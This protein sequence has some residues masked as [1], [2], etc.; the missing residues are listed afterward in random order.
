MYEKNRKSPLKSLPV[1]TVVF[2]FIGFPKSHSTWEPLVFAWHLICIQ[3][4]QIKLKLTCF[5]FSVLLTLFLTLYLC[6]DPGPRVR[7]RVWKRD[8]Q[9][10]GM[11]VVPILL[12]EQGVGWRIGDGDLQHHQTLV[13]QREHLHA[14]LIPKHTH[15]HTFMFTDTYS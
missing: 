3:S 11:G 13:G 10:S 8:E 1:L 5:H 12:G 14:V 4:N 6:R 2:R 7:Q 15:T 9:L